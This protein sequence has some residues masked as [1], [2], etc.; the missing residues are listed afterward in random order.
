MTVQRTPLEWAFLPLKR[1]AQASGRANRAEY[2]WFTFAIFLVCIAVKFVDQPTGSEISVLDLMFNFG[3]MIP[4]ATV[5]VRRLHDTNRTGWWLLAPVIPGIVFG[6]QTSQAIL[7]EIFE[8]WEPTPTTLI[9]ISAF[10]VASAVL[11]IFTI[12]PGTC[13]PN[14]YG[15][16]PYGEHANLD[17]V[18]F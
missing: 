12:L 10:V 4:T 6:F 16:D 11:L 3:I 7:L 15:P 5:T 9:S 13:G 14:R 17:S 18:V 1:Y 8:V 2:W